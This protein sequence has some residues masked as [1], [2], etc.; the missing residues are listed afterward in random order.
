MTGLAKSPLDRAKT[1]EVIWDQVGEILLM[2]GRVEDASFVYLIGEEAGPLKI[3]FAKDPIQRLRSMQTGNPRPLRLERVLLGD[4]SIERLLHKLWEPFAII[5][6]SKKG[7]VDCAPG[8]EWFR[9]EIREQLDPIIETAE[10]AQVDYLVACE[11][12]VDADELTRIVRE[13][14]IKHGHVET[15]RDKVRLLRR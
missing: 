10:I 11:R 2:A 1:H 15:R 13:A 4:M 5:S 12:E 9:A 14:H 7:K 6:P 3:G 8:T